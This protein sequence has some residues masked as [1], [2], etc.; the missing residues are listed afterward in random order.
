MHDIGEQYLYSV[1]MVQHLILSFF[2]PPM[3]LKATPEWL[4]GWCYSTTAQ[5]LVGS[6]AWLVPVPTAIL[7][8]GVVI[9]LHWQ[10]AVTLSMENAP[11]HF[12]MHL[13]LFSTSL[14]MWTPVVGPLPEMRISLP[15]RMVYLFMQS[16]VPTVPG[17]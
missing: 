16:I 10:S 5:R 2:V 15:A 11:F 6:V 3:F 14:L 17:A 1:H 4:A 12:G 7:F 9:F 13:L 8:N